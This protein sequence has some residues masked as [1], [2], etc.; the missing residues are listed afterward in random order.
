MPFGSPSLLHQASAILTRQ[1]GDA[2]SPNNYSALEVL[3]TGYLR[4]THHMI[5]IALALFRRRP[6]LVMRDKLLLTLGSS[7][8]KGINIRLLPPNHVRDLRVLTVHLK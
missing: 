5:K 8:I 2:F 7:K 6:R 3:T 1:A 4:P